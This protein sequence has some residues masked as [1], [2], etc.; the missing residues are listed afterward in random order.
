[1]FLQAEAQLL[2]EQFVVTLGLHQFG[3]LCV[4]AVLEPEQLL[5]HLLKFYEGSERGGWLGWS[6]QAVAALAE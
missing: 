2:L 3:V 5:P 6:E 4:E 1:M